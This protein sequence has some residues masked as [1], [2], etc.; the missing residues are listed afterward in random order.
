MINNIKLFKITY[1]GF[2]LASLLA[3]SGTKA[4]AQTS[5]GI[6]IK[7]SV[8]NE[9]LV[10]GEE[11]VF[12]FTVENQSEI[13]QTYYFLKKDIVGAGD[14]GAPIFADDSLEKTNFDLSQW[15]SLDQDSIFVPA[16]G[17][18][19]INFSIKV[20]NDISPGDHFASIIT[21]SKPPEIKKTG[22][23]V[24]YQV[25]NIISIRT[26]G[27]VVDLAKIREFST[28]RYFYSNK[29]VD[30]KIKIENDGN[31]LVKPVGVVSVK[32]MFGKTVAD[33]DFNSSASGVFPKTKS[34]PDGVRIFNLNWEEE[35]LGFG[36]YEASLSVSYGSEQKSSLYSTVTFWILPANVIIPTIII[37]LVI[38]LIVYFLVKVHIKKKVAMLT[39]GAGR[40]L[41]NNRK[42][43]QFPTFLVF[44][45]MLVLTI[46]ILMVLVLVLS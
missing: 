42:Q 37:L 46:L 35:G 24:G 7:P 27:E 4:L 23:S 40:R 36:R 8:I 15:I 34:N 26:P 17:V 1:F 19:T 25:G 10:E 45:S 31:V 5:E 44:L 32:N 6:G 13:D 29:K 11:K 33:I 22:A 43:N 28:G 39:G 20:P 16:G 2:L 9:A 14:N 3:I 18:S 30:F 38:F 12:S 21:S 41:V